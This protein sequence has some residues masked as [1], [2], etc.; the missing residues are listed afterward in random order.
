MTLNN[1]K[2][3]DQKITMSFLKQQTLDMINKFAK[4]TEQYLN[5]VVGEANSGNNGTIGQHIFKELVRID[6]VLNQN[7]KDLNIMFKNLCKISQLSSQINDIDD[8]IRESI[9]P[10]EELEKEM[11]ETLHHIKNDNSIIF[12]SSWNNFI[13]NLDD[14]IP[15][16]IQMG[17][18]TYAPPFDNE[19]PKWFGP[20]APQEDLMRSSL[21]YQQQIDS[22]SSNIKPIETTENMEIL[23]HSQQQSRPIF[24]TD[25][26]THLLAE[27]D[28]ILENTS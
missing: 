4:S 8:W 13:S 28:W 24:S 7:I 20:P 25:T 17:K 27:E 1:V 23:P 10:Y 16:A 26:V 21:L 6:K 22:H 3:G 15:W 19:I 12:T 11:L 5:V 14:I 2:N 18:V 9:H